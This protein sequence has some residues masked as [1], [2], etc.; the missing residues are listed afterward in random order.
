MPE[1]VTGLGD[2]L[3]ASGLV[4]LHVALS[5]LVTAHV[6]LRKRE[7]A[8]AIGWIGLAWLSPLLGSALY[9]LLG[10]NRVRQRA[11]TLGRPDVGRPGGDAEPSG[12]RPG[13]ALEAIDRTA[14]RLSRRRAT[15]A[16]SSR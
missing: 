12:H 9:Y 8:A 11:R 5:A 1:G 2:V 7:V 10:I 16:W 4:V 15:P 3:S 6:L 14:R 13:S